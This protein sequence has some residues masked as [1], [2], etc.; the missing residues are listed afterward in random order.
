M[1]AAFV[2]EAVDIKLPRGAYEGGGRDMLTYKGRPVCC[3]TRGAPRPYLH[4]VWTPAGHIVTAERPADH[5]HHSGIW[6]ASDHVGLMMLG[7]D[8]CERYDYNFYVD[9]TFQGRAS[10]CIRQTRISLSHQAG[11]TAT[12]EQTLHWI[13]PREWAAPEGRHVLT[14]RRL[15]EVT[16]SADAVVLD[17]ES[18]VT[19]AGEVPV[20][21]GPTRHAWFNARLNDGVALSPAARPQDDRGHRGADAIAQA[22]TH[23][24]KVA[25]WIGVA[26]PLGGGMLAGITMIPEA[27][28]SG[29]FVTDWG[30]LTSSPIRNA[31]VDIAAG[32]SVRFACRFIAHDG[33]PPGNPGTGDCP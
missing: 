8:G 22:A 5:P 25:S 11:A 13:G 16:M 30:V 17:I 20:R 3:F 10:G 12:I 14:E 18:W 9:D 19:P 27:P 33:P 28:A 2:L 15:T 6:C 32:Q 31:P 4:P 21:L 7:P 24:G 1:T 29:W 26:G 23:N